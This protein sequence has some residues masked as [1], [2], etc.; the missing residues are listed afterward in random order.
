MNEMAEMDERLKKRIFLFYAAAAVNLLLAGFVLFFARGV[1][2]D[3]K[4]TM[5]LVLCLSFVAV[6]LWM[7]QLIKKKWK[8]DQAKQ[9]AQRKAMSGGPGSLK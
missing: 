2:P 5:L 1:L 9:E 8:E 6:T 4:L 3:D 7:P